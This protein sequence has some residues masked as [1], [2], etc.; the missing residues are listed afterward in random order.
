MACNKVS[1]FS[2]KLCL[3]RRRAVEHF[4]VQHNIFELVGILAR[5]SLSENAHDE[6]FFWQFFFSNRE[7]HFSSLNCRAYCAGMLLRLRDSLARE[8]AWCNLRDVQQ[9]VDKQQVPR[10]GRKRC[11]T[12][13]LKEFVP[14]C[15]IFY[16]TLLDSSSRDCALQPEPRFDEIRRGPF[17][18]AR[19]L[20]Q[21]PRLRSGFR[22]QAP[23]SPKALRVTPAYR[24]NFLVRVISAV[25]AI[26]GKV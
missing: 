17:G 10:R 3:G 2:L 5:T 1:G 8:F 13:P 21:I 4:V 20:N 12:I 19:R 15:S 11:S 16:C 23:P 18:N 6:N 24:I 25:R 9:R 22:Q 7:R 14:G 26:R